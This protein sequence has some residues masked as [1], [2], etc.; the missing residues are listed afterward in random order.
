M[1][2][3]EAAK[4]RRINHIAS[5]R[6]R[7]H[8]IQGGGVLSLEM[9][10]RNAAHLGIQR[11]VQG[12]DQGRFSHAGL[13][14]KEDDFAGHI[15]PQR[16]HTL[17]RH[18]RGFDDRIARSLVDPPEIGYFIGTLVP[19]QIHLVQDHRCRDAVHLAR[20]QKAVQE[21]QFD[22]R[23]IQ[24]DNQIGPIDVGCDH[25]RSARQVRGFP[26][27]VV[28][29]VQHFRNHRR[30]LQRRISLAGPANQVA[31]RH[32]VG[33]RPSFQTDLPF[34]DRREGRPDGQGRK[35]VMASGILYHCC[36]S[37]HPVNLQ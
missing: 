36:C 14:G 2:Q 30:G 25:V 12:F 13:S 1:H 29:P 26:D 11:G 5:A 16:L 18:G 21:S 37:F 33:R 19:V 3:S 27:H 17:P 10:I 20:D 31:H 4:P 34:Q 35:Q 24:G 7:V 32:R 23:K 8:F 28:L 6:K 9:H 22:L 15:G